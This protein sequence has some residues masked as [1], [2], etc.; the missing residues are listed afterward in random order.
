MT[1][2]EAATAHPAGGRGSFEHAEARTTARS[3]ASVKGKATGN[4][5]AAAK[6]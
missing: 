2:A 3:K 4:R 1:A 5:K 6:P